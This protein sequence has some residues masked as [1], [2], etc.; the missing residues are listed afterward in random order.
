[1]VAAL[2]AHGLK[3]VHMARFGLGVKDLT[4]ELLAA[5]TAGANVVFGYTVG[6]EN[7]VITFANPS[8]A[9]RN[10]LVQRKQQLGKA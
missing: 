3:A 5:P 1:M 7:A 4:E 9:K 8:D 10:W 6:T 2:A